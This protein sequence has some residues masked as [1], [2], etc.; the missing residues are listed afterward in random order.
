MQSKATYVF[1]K[2]TKQEGKT[3]FNENPIGNWRVI[4][5]K[6]PFNSIH[7]FVWQ[8]LSFNRFYEYRICN[9]ANEIIAYARVMPKIF[10]FGFIP[11]KE[12]KSMHIGPCFTSEKY[13]GM[14][15]YPY[16]LNIL[17]IATPK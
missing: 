11:K 9:D 15:F 7:S 17:L 13:R 6:M 8:I 10:V 2:F 3:T 12:K 16:L 1:Y 5:I 4:K 14:G